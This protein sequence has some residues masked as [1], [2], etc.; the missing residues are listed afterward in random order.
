MIIWSLFDSETACVA[1]TFAGEHEVYSFGVGSGTNHVHLD[2][3]D[4]AEAKKVLDTYP[5]PDVIFASPPCGSWVVV[6]VGSLKCFTSETA[7]NLFW[8]NKDLEPIYLTKELTKKRR[9]GEDTAICTAKIIQHYSPKFWAIENGNSSL[10]FN[11]MKKYAGLAG[12]K[13]YCNYFSYGFN[14]LKPTII[15]SN[16]KLNLLGL[17]ADRLLDGTTDDAKGEKRKLKKSGRVGILRKEFSKAYDGAPRPLPPHNER[18]HAR[19][20]AD[21]VSAFGGG[22]ICT[23]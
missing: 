17:P 20:P 14:N 2:L 8:K 1:S 21:I 22:L 18:V 4:F 11:F 15:Y 19:R 16:L 13:N 3:S 9:D 23:Q 10:I 6:S 12:Y 5:K 7:Y